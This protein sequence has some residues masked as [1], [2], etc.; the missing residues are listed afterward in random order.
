MIWALLGS[1]SVRLVGGL[2]LAVSALWAAL[3][4]N[5]SQQRNIGAARVT[6]KIEEKANDNAATALAVREAVAKG[7]PG[8][9]D[10]HMRKPD[11]LR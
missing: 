4:L 5:N 1:R 6:V 11:G 3:A 7:A 8:K 10:P 9:P 2:F